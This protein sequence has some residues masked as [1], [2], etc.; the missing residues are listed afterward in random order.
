MGIK[1]IGRNGMP[2]TMPGVD[3]DMDVIARVAAK[4]ALGVKGVL[5]LENAFADGIAAALGMDGRARGVRVAAAG[6][7]CSLQL[8]AVTEYGLNIPEI[9][10]N[11]QEHV[12]R[13]VENILGVH[14]E[15]VNVFISGIREA[16]ARP[17]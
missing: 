13:T 11:M 16:G 1:L 8:C 15:Q 12:K 7:G 14:V 9:A 10:W 4:A 3:I 6:G 2:E 17:Q 5:A